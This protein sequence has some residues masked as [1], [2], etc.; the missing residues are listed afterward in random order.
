MDE[1]FLSQHDFQ[2]IILQTQ[3]AGYLATQN[4]CSPDHHEKKRAGNAPS[5]STFNDDV[6]YI[7][8]LHRHHRNI[9]PRLFLP[10]RIPLIFR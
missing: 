9:L 5:K 2:P 6:V 3:K 1:T 8:F 10:P 4:S 7:T